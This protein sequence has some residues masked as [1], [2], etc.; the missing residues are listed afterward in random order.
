MTQEADVATAERLGRR[1]ARMLPVLGVFFLTQQAAFFANPPGERAVDHVR[2]GAWVV[3]SAVLLFV[4][5]TGGG[6]FRSPAVRA[7]L[8]DEPTRANRASAMHWGF[9]AAMIA[10]IVLYVA[11]GVSAFTARE[12][13]HLIVSAG[14]VAALVRFGMLERRAHA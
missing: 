4:L 12:I 9:L 7:M 2:I 13:I 1:R 11:Q 6:L 14:M 10:G 3:M 8:N 5:H